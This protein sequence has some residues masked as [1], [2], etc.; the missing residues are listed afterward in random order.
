MVLPAIVHLKFES[1]S[2]SKLGFLL[3]ISLFFVLH[4]SCN[5]SSKQSGDPIARVNERYLY[6]TD[7]EDIFPENVSPAD[8]IQL[9]TAYADRWVKKQLLLQKA[10]R[11]LSKNRKD[12]ARQIEDYRSSLL[13]FQYEQEYIRQRLDT[14]VNDDEIER[15]Y[16]ENLSNFI[17][18]ESVVKA[19]FIK[20]RLDNPSYD[21]IK[22]LYKSNKEDDI[23]ALDNMAY[24]VAVK[25]DFFNDRWIPFSRILRELPEPIND[26]ERH[27]LYNK[28]IEMNDDAHAYLVNFREVM[29]QGKI[30]PMEFE[31]ENIRSIIVNKRKQRLILDLESRIY[32]DARNH[33]HFTIYVN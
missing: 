15:F 16:E 6:I 10:E 5:P 7:V 9:L 14:V 30:S 27:L 23:K 29:H 19:L 33:N 28:S 20:I 8:S 13:I 3:I 17:L 25:Y 18:N 32:N 31:R 11:N 22:G 24:Q 4:T 1:M 2:S 26:P 21:K 12:V